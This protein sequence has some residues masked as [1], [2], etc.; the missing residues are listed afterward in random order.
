MYSFLSFILALGFAVVHFTSKYMKFLT[1]IP[2][3]GLLSVASG[4]SVAYVFVHILPELKEHQENI[5][6]TG[7]SEFFRYLDSHVY[8]FAMFG[9]CTFYGIE[10]AVKHSQKGV[11]GETSAG[12]FLLHMSA[13]FLYNMLIGYL[14]IHG[15]FE[16]MKEWLMYFIALAVHFI[17]NDHG[18]RQSHKRVYD[19]YGRWVLSLSVLYGW[20]IGI[21]TEVS[22]MIIAF[23]FSVL[24]G[25]V[26]LNVL[27]EELPEGRESNFGAFIA[28]AAGYTI[29]LMLI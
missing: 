10:K 15:E 23:L 29:I 20:L 22:D 12:L 25:G 3:S 11:K 28:G 9:L 6:G 24:A 27:K 18:L 4:I 26:I 2:R 16:S 17:S 14:L 5:E 19:Q 8:I 13:F 7:M 1:Y 21:L